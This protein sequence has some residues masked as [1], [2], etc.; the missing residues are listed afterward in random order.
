MQSIKA[1]IK[2]DILLEGYDSCKAF[3]EGVC[4][5]MRTQAK[6]RGSAAPQ[7]EVKTNKSE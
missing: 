3:T 1:A 5:V 2:A 7:S 6:R 4:E